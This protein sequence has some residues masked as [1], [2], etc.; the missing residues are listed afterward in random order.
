MVGSILI[1]A[2]AYTALPQ[3]CKLANDLLRMRLKKHGYYVAATTPGLWRH[4]W[5]PVQFLLIINDFGTE[6]VSECHTQHLLGV[7]KSL[8]AGFIEYW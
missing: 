7:L 4:K 6:Y 5:R 8:Y 2:K 1:Y 3:S